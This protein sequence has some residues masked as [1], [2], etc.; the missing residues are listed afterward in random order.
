VKANAPWRSAGGWSG[1]TRRRGCQAV[2]WHSGGVGG[3][4]PARLAQKGCA[5]P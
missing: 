2:A 1:R 5:T 3:L 4:R